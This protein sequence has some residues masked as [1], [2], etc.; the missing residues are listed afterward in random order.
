PQIP[1]LDVR[2]NADYTWRA[3]SVGA[4]WRIVAPQRRYTLHEGNVV[5]Q[6]FGPSAGFGV[7][8]L[9]AQYDLDKR[10][11]FSIGVD[12]LFNKAYSEHLNLAGNAGFG[13]S[14]GVAI[15]EPGRTIW[16]RLR[17]RM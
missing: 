2:L 16:G 12:N 17:F 13:Y 7:V 6:D 9:H 5:G 1:P 10:T 4:L 15:M 14:G 8:S 3:W 11:Q